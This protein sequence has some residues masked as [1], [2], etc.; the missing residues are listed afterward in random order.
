MNE[1][2]SKDQPQKLPFMDIGIN[3]EKRVEDLLSRL[4][5]EEK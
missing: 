4:T 5:L 3:L 2:Y 1:I